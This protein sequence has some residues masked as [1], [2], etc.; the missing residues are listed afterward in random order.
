MTIKSFIRKIPGVCH[1]WRALDPLRSKWNVY[2][3]FAYDRRRFLKYSRQAYLSRE[4]ILASIIAAY[5]VIEKGLTMP[6]MRF[7]FGRDV[8]LNLIAELHKFADQY[9][10]ND[11]QFRCAVAVIAEYNLVHND[12]GFVFDEEREQAIKALLSRFPESPS[13][14]IEVTREQYFSN[15][16]APFDIFSASRHSVRHFEGAISID[17]IKRAVAL[18]RNAPSFCNRQPCRVHLISSPDEVQRCLALQNGNRGFGHLV[19][20]LLI[21]TSDLRVARN[22][23]RND[24]YTNSG[25]FMMNLSYALHRNEVAHCLLNWSVLPDV[26]RQLRRIVSI[27]EPESIVVLIGCGSS[28]KYFKLAISPRKNID[29]ILMIH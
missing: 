4:G 14:Q 2:Q 7:G 6:N 20:K 26:D 19:D 24:V 15:I 28:P 23:E 11:Q 18:A 8:L 12:A 3:L 17:Q 13:M 16:T 5:H 10:A 9:G 1:Y 22:T 25:I 21:I 29:E 27:P